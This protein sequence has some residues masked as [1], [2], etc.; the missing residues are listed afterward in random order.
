MEG[1]SASPL[2]KTLPMSAPQRKRRIFPYSRAIRLD[3]S[4]VP[5]KSNI[6]SVRRCRRPFSVAHHHA[7]KISALLSSVGQFH[8][9]ST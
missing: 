9:V 8:V 1:D 3:N 2:G 7:N 6:A 4:V 5:V